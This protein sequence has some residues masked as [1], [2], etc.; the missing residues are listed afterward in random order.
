LQKPYQ[1]VLQ[2]KGGGLTTGD[3][4]NI[5]KASNSGSLLSKGLA[6]NLGRARYEKIKFL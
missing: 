5:L 6:I 4:S 1:E 2:E 3:Y